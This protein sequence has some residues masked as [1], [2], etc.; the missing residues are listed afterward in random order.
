MRS[1]T[2]RSPRSA[3]SES[4]RT[5]GEIG[6]TNTTDPGSVKSRC[7]PIFKVKG[8][9][10]LNWGKFYL[11]LK[12]NNL[13]LLGSVARKNICPCYYLNSVSYCLVSCK[14]IYFSLFHHKSF[15]ILYSS[16]LYMWM[17]TWGVY[18]PNV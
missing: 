18:G 2:A 14:T 15:N 8:L 3:T 1:S 5:L 16:S 17:T 4:S 6:N 10:N 9:M 12:W 7:F 13:L 11:H